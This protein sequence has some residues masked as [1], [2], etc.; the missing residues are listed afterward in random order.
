MNRGCLEHRENIR[1]FD[2]SKV[3]NCLPRYQC[4][5][6]EACI[7]NNSSENTG[8]GDIQNHTAQV[9]SG[10]ALLGAACL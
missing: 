1:T 2:Q 10:T 8:G 3:F 6:L 9:I 5:Q 7:D 4:H